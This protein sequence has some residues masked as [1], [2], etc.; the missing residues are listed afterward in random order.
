VRSTA[1]STS[2]SRGHLVLGTK[3]HKTT[4]YLLKAYTMKVMFVNQKM[5]WEIISLC[6]NLQEFRKAAYFLLEDRRHKIISLFKI[7]QLE[8][9]SE[10]RTS[11]GDTRDGVES[12]LP[13]GQIACRFTPPPRNYDLK[14]KST[15]GFVQSLIPRQSRGLNKA[16]N[17]SKR[18]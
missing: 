6:A 9:N 5:I 13:D 7:W 3:R 4:F 17:R 15:P 1:F 11:G 8:E 10:S 2:D 12:W 16:V 14:D 18:I